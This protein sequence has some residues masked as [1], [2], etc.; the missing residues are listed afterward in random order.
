MLMKVSFPESLPIC[1]NGTNKYSWTIKGIILQWNINMSAI[2]WI[3]YTHEYRMNNV[4]TREYRK[5]TAGTQMPHD[6]MQ[7]NGKK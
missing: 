3:L 1:Y 6:Y 7:E 2:I 5:N 4:G